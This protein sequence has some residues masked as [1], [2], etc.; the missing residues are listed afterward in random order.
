MIGRFRRPRRQ[1]PRASR[2]R[3]HTAGW[4]PRA[5]ESAAYALRRRHPLTHLYAERSQQ[6]GSWAAGPGGT[7]GGLFTSP[8]S[9]DSRPPTGRAGAPCGDRPAAGPAGLK[10]GPARTHLRA[11]ERMKEEGRILGETCGTRQRAGQGCAGV[12]SAGLKNEGASDGL[13]ESPMAQLRGETS[14]EYYI[15]PGSTTMVH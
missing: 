7:P 15:K 11:R 14:Q 12:A 3:P 6:I 2:V 13:Y 10:P 5:G 8:R 4:R 1:C 9:R